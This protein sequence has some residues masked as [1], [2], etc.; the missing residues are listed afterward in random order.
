MSLMSWNVRGLGNKK[1]VRSLKSVSF[2]FK[3]SIIFLSETK[4]KRR[5]L[6]KIKMK[7]K[8][9]ESFYVDPIGIAGGLTLWWKNKVNLSIL[10]YGKNF[11]DTRV[12]LNEEEEWN[13]IPEKWCLIGDSNIVARL[14]EKLGGLP[15]DPSNA[16][17][18]Y[19][20]IDYSCLVELPIKDWSS[21]FLKAIG[22]IDVAIASDHAPVI[23]LLK[24]MNKKYKRD[25]KFEAKWI[26]E[27]ECTTHVE[28]SWFPSHDRSGNKAFERKLSRK[29]VKL[30]QWSKAK[31]RKSK[32]YEE[33]MIER[34]KILQEKH[35]S[36]DE[37]EELI[38]L[39][40]ELD[41]LWEGE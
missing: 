13:N 5:Y 20:F 40:K 39:K 10:C 9:S 12:S 29:R 8:L 26:L 28:E 30:R 18:Y 2:K 23:L 41:R 21:A 1:T 33:E 36:K 3:S 31:G 4:K 34:I 16:M 25:F 32:P 15:F 37:M 6:E 19:D 7:M 11:I 35:P 27:N 17:W 14:K 24:G 22:L 38:S